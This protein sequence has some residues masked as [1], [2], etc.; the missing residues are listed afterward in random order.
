MCRHDICLEPR[1]VG[2]QAKGQFHMI[3]GTEGTQVLF[4]GFAREARKIRL[5][6]QRAE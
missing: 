3:Y 4:A 2:A 6:L 1:I 5:R